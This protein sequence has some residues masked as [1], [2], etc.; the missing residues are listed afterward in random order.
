MS[1]HPPMQLVPGGH[2]FTTREKYDDGTELEVDDW[3]LDKGFHSGPH[4]EACGQFICEHCQ[5]GVWTE[6]CEGTQVIVLS[7]SAARR[8]LES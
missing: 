5:P 6:A 1:E 8:G 2:V 7:E 3:Q 4:C